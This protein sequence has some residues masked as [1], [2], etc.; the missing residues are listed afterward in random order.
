MT[1]LL[2]WFLQVI[3]IFTFPWSC[4]FSKWIMIHGDASP[5]GSSPGFGKG[6][7]FHFWWLPCSVTKED[8]EHKLWVLRPFEKSHI[9]KGNTINL[10]RQIIFVSMIWEGHKFLIFRYTD[11]QRKWNFLFTQTDRKSPSL[12]QNL[13]FIYIKFLWLFS[14]CQWLENDQ[15]KKYFSNNKHCIHKERKM[16]I[17]L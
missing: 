3:D 2:L 7:S 12:K 8:S 17:P 9:L 5:E 1:Y 16:S 11:Q 15:F 4:I 14:L 6:L 13:M 10:S